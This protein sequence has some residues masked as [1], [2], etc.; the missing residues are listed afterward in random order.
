ME[1][2]DDAEDAVVEED[3]GGFEGDGGAEVED[4]DGEEGLFCRAIELELSLFI[5]YRYT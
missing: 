4:L 3:K 2:A 5:T 1:G